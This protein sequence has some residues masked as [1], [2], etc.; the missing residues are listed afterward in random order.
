[1]KTNNLVSQLQFPTFEQLIIGAV[2]GTII[3]LLVGYWLK[4]LVDKKVLEDNQ[5]LKKLPQMS[6]HKKAGPL[7]AIWRM[8]GV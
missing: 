6:W 5:R 8:L 4:N 2:F 7:T 3:G 1:M